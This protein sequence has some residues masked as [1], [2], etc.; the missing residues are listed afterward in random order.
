MVYEDWK[1]IEIMPGVA[2]PTP[3]S[4][5]LPSATLACSND[6]YTKTNPFKRRRWA[7]R[8]RCGNILDNNATLQVVFI[9]CHIFIY[10]QDIFYS[11]N[12]RYFYHWSDN[13]MYRLASPRREALD[14][15]W[16]LT[17]STKLSVR[18]ALEQRQKAR[19]KKTLTLALAMLTLHLGLGHWR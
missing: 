17:L 10:I 5:L 16:L 12:Q 4:T 14:L 8:G 15:S 19:F 11:C 7:K 1:E 9:S 13:P 18:S 2:L 3:P 6:N